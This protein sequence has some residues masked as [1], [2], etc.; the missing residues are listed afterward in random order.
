[1]QSTT[2]QT[3]ELVESVKCNDKGEVVRGWTLRESWRTQQT[4]NGQP[5]FQVEFV[6]WTVGGCEFP[7]K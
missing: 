3:I 5:G 4:V 1:M 6:P 2:F 7:S